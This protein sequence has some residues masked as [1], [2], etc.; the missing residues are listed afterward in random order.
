MLQRSRFLSVIGGTL[1]L[2]DLLQACVS[3]R[4]LKN[5]LP[6]T[7]P[8]LGWAASVPEGPTVELHQL[9]VRNSGGSWVRDADWDE[10]VLTI[11][12]DSPDS[13]E[14][15]R[16]DLYSDKLPAPEQSSTS[17]EQLDARTGRTLRAMKDVGVVAGAGVVVP[18]AL[19]AG[20]IGAGGGS[21]A[22]VGAA[23]AVGAVAIPVGLIGGTVYV[24][25]RHYRDKEDKVLIERS[26]MERGFGV[27]VQILPGMQVGTSAFYPVTPSPTRLVVHYAAG[28]SS[29]EI[30]LDLPALAGL[31]LKAPR[32][33]SV[34]NAAPES[35]R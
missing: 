33:T 11:R 21:L 34:S 22:T 19:M 10:Y 7:V 6:P 26:L 3:S 29:R 35:M 25:K 17:R 23:A 18:T 27:P 9:I 12:N 31:H 1:V 4:L 15:Q 8:D 2:C 14:I 13:I 24:V 30:P 32:F 5:P 28:D 20:T 16:I